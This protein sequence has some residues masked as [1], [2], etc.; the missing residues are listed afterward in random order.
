MSVYCNVFFSKFNS[1]KMTNLV[2][3]IPLSSVNTD[4]SISEKVTVI[5]TQKYFLLSK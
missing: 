2:V 3:G 4:T 5:I 1:M